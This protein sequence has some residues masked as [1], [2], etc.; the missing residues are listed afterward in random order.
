VPAP[1]D[2]EL[3]AAGY[4]ASFAEGWALLDVWRATTG[5]RNPA[6]GYRRL[7]S[8]LQR[9]EVR[10]RDGGPLTEIEKELRVELEDFKRQRDARIAASAPEEPRS[11]AEAVARGRKPPDLSAG[12]ALDKLQMLADLAAKLDVGKPDEKEL[13]K[14]ASERAAFLK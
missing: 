8:T 10:W 5:A 9:A 11:L 7:Q 6:T 3:E 4:P 12:D 2:E 13:A 1:T 14:L